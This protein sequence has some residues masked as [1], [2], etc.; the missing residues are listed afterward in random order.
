M[1]K[2]KSLLFASVLTTTV[3]LSAENKIP[4]IVIDSKLDYNWSGLLVSKFRVLMNNYGVQDPFKARFDGSIV[5]SEA[6]VGEFL[7]DESLPLVNDLGN[8]IGLRLVNS[9]TKVE[10]HG[11]NYEVKDF[12]TDLKSAQ[13]ETDGLVISTDFSASEITLAADKISLSLVIPTRNSSAVTPIIA[14]DIIKPRI[15]GKESRLISLLT[16]IKIQDQKDSYK[17]QLQKANFNNM[18]QSLIRYP[19]D[20]ELDYER[21]IVPEL[22]LRIG[23]K[24]IEFSPQK[25]E[26]LLESKHSAI[27]G[28]LL[29]QV[30]SALKNQTAASTSALFEKHKIPKEYWISSDLIKSQMQIS[31]FKN[32]L[33]SNHFEV[34]IPGDFCTTQNY[35][36]L[37]EECLNNKITKT[38]ETRLTSKLYQESVNAMR[39]LMDTG[40]ANLVASISEDYLNKL[41]VTT[42]DAG[43]WTAA[44]DEAGVKL[45]PNKVT[46]RMDKKGDSGTLLMDVIYKPSR[47]ERFALGAKEIRFPLVLDISVRIEK[48]DEEPVAIVRLNDVDLSDE[49]LINGKPEHNIVSTIQDVPRFRG[50]VIDTIR[51]K[52]IS[53]KDKDIIELR[54]PEFKGLGLENVDFLSDGNGRMNALMRLEDLLENQG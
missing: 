46:M 18:A 38:S 29:A 36:K 12:R 52:I 49:T 4:D 31:R 21:I 1:K 42:Y 32:T 14:I 39:E 53:L 10:M 47:L 22:E 43:L 48:H 5:V 27:K 7:S 44:L 33:G 34:Q 37:K 8:V 23:S 11:F 20:V 19:D 26:R 54:Y 45:G 51:E 41:L 40:D 50:K 2:L 15:K 16:Q 17:F 35:N 9:Q 24:K 30:A 13:E 28:I 25:I 6:T 3:V